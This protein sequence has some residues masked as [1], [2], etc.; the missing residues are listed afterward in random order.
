MASPREALNRLRWTGPGSLRGVLIY[1]RHRGA[2][3]DTAV[4]RGDDVL[5]VGRSFLDL[6][7]GVRIPHHRILRIEVG[8]QTVWQRTRVRSR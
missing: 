1:Y 3:Q 2:P 5:N 6:P 4:L 7:H 8:G